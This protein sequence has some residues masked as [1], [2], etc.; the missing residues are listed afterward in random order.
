VGTSA[1]FGKMG[2][3]NVSLKKCMVKVCLEVMA[4]FIEGSL[5]VKLPTIWTV[6]K[7]R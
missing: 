5:E 1:V 2:D 3:V 6:E 7:Q 4:E